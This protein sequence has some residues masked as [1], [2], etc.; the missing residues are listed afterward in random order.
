MSLIREIVGQDARHDQQEHER[1]VGK[2]KYLGLAA[3]HPAGV[4][5]EDDG[6]DQQNLA[7][8]VEQGTLGQ[9]EVEKQQGQGRVPGL[10]HQHEKNREQQI[11]ELNRQRRTADSHLRTIDHDQ[12]RVRGE[13][14]G[15]K[16]L[17]GDQVFRRTGELE[18]QVGQR[19]GQTHRRQMRETSPANSDITRKCSRRH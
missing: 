12:D 4:E 11:A 6:G 9:Y 14:N 16:R 8:A 19:E 17:E 18:D 15:E 13:G 2:L 7:T 5:H 1:A 10:R 3:G